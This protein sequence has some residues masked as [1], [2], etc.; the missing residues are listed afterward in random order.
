MPTAVLRSKAF[1]EH[2][3]LNNEARNQRGR[4]AEGFSEGWGYVGGDFAS[5]VAGQDTK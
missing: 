5:A 2:S 1:G 4:Q 3:K